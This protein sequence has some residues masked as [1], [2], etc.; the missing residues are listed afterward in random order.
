MPPGPARARSRPARETPPPLS[1]AAD[2]AH[3]ARMQPSAAVTTTAPTIFQPSA[4][5]R[6]GFGLLQQGRQL[7]HMALAIEQVAIRR[8]RSGRDRIGFQQK[9]HAEPAR[10]M[11]PPALMRGP[12]KKP[13]CQ[14]LGRPTAQTA[15]VHVRR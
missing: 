11:R 3:H 8:S 12:S 7:D 1:R 9:I 14:G 6:L 15:Y 2:Q 10:P 13:R 5:Q 4:A